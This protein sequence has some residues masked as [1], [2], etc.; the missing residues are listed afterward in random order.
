VVNPIFGSAA[1]LTRSTSGPHPSFRLFACVLSRPPSSPHFLSCV[2]SVLA[3]VSRGKS[4]RPSRLGAV[5]GCDRITAFLLVPTAR[6]LVIEESTNIS[7]EELFLLLTIR[8][9]RPRSKHNFVTPFRSNPKLFD[10]SLLHLSGLHLQLDG[11]QLRSGPPCEAPA[12]FS[13][14]RHPPSPN[15]AIKPRSQSLPCRTY[16]IESCQLFNNPQTAVNLSSSNQSQHGAGF[17]R[18]RHTGYRFEI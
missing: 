12:R 18:S 2:Y 9:R 1:H 5:T 4:C 13:D 16:P 6:W 11:H 17:L 8:T 14:T 7:V 15:D 10:L 3:P